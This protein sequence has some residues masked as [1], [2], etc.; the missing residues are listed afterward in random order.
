[1]SSNL[2]TTTTVTVSVQGTDAGGNN[3]SSNA[4]IAAFTNTTA[5]SECTA[6]YALTM[7]FQTIYVPLISAGV[8]AFQKATIMPPTG[9]FGG[10]LTLKGVTGD[11]GIAIDNQSFTVLGLPSGTLSFGLTASVAGEIQIK[12][13]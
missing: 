3:I 12:W 1:M 5:V 4:T 9:G 7:G 13:G 2:T 11:T 6:P 8:A 10:T